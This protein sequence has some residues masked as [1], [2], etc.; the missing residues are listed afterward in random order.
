MSRRSSGV[1]VSDKKKEAALH[2]APVDTPIMHVRAL[3][4][5]EAHLV[6]AERFLLVAHNLEKQGKLTESR[7]YTL[8]AALD[9]RL[10]LARAWSALA[11]SCRPS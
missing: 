1:E 3:C 5:A 8:G 6:E 11:A 10:R 7:E 2:P 9:V 4:K